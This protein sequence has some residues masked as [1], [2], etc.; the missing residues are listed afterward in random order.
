[1]RESL[2]ADAEFAAG[3]GVT[4]KEAMRRVRSAV[5]SHAGRHKQ[6]A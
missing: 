4:H 5:E 6:A 3:K 2:A 1:M